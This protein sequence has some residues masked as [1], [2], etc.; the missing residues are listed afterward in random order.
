MG[1]NNMKYSNYRSNV[2]G[3]NT[4]ESD[5][6]PKV[7]HEVHYMYCDVSCTV[8]VWATDPMDA[9]SI[10]REQHRKESPISQ[11]DAGFFIPKRK[12]DSNHDDIN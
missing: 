10:M 8:M 12:E 11:Q 5:L 4:A 9:I 3:P 7:W 2:S 1:E 6:E